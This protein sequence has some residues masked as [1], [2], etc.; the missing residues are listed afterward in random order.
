MLFTLYIK[1]LASIISKFGFIYH[2]YADDVQC[3]VT[4]DADKT[5]DANVLT[6]KGQKSL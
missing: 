4:F 2:F 6:N 1:P 5:L 3:Y